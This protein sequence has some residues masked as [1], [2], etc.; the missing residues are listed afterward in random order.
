MLRNRRR[1]LEHL[2]AFRTAM[3]RALVGGAVEMAHKNNARSKDFP[4]VG[5]SRDELARGIVL[6]EQ[7][8]LTRNQDMDTSNDRG[9]R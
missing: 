7:V 2:E 3:I 4:I 5:V 8:Q 1:R 6:D 9:D